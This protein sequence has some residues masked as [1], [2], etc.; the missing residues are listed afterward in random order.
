MLVNRPG[1]VRMPANGIVASVMGSMVTALVMEPLSTMLRCASSVKDDFGV[2]GPP[3]L[4]SNSFSR[5]GA[6]VGEYGLRVFQKSSAKFHCADPRY[7]SEP[8]L[9]KISILSLIHIS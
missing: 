1:V 6:L 8:G 3:A 7:L 9:V 4:P 2:S 5:K